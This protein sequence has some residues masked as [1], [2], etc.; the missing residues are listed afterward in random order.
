MALLGMGLGSHGG[1]ITVKRGSLLKFRNATVLACIGKCQT[2]MR[3]QMSRRVPHLR[4]KR[5]E[6]VCLTAIYSVF[7][8]KV[9]LLKS[10]N[11]IRCLNNDL[12]KITCQNLLKS[13]HI[14]I[15]F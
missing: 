14:S 10:V 15:A 6:I 12:L 11:C 1:Q 13:Y 8:R 3:F 4:T 9:V 2:S 7:Q 5:S